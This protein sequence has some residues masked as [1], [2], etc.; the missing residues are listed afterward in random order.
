MATFSRREVLRLAASLGLIPVAGAISACGGSSAASLPSYEFEGQPGPATLFSHAV[1]SGDPLSDAVILWTRVSTQGDEAVSV[2]WEMA[3]DEDFLDRVAAGWE[4]TDSSLDYTVKVDV[5]GLD[6]GA[7]YYYR[8]HALGRMSPVGRTKTA[9]T[10][11]QERMRIGVVS[12]SFYSIGYFHAYRSLAARED[13]DVVVH[14]GDY[15][16][17]YAAG[18][19]R[20]HLPAHEIITLD[21]YRQ[22]YAQYH[23]DP[24]LQAAHRQHPWILVWDDHESAN[25]SWKGGASN[26]Q[27]DEGAWQARKA[28][29]AQA[30]SEWLPIR[31][32][33]DG[34][35]FRSF[36]F[37]DL[38][39]L[40]MLDTRIWGRDKAAG[41]ASDSAVMRDPE[42]TLLGFD[43]EEWVAGEMQSSSARWFVLG[44]QIVM[45]QWKLQGLP[46]AEGGGAVANAD[47]WDGYHAA[48]E[49]LFDAVEDAGRGNLIVLTGD[50]HSS[51]AADLTRDP[52]E[53]SHYDPQTGRGS[54]GVEMV[55]SSVT[56]TFSVP[57]LE[58]VIKTMNP[59]LKYGETVSRGYLLLDLDH[60]RA[61]GEWYHFDDVSKVE[62]T[63][64]LAAIWA[65]RDGAN[66]LEEG[67]AAALPTTPGGT[68]LTDI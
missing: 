1:A 63:E 56:S 44:Q 14:L 22:R 45:H 18:G 66:H 40:T 61:Q 37:G 54:L 27:E 23:T 57:G 43:Q 2:F 16:Y 36:R 65:T 68:G 6:A 17:E 39:D 4:G 28:A 34:R 51:W 33:E 31:D 26:H 64:R 47:Q 13:L 7:T 20:A 10:G 29:A 35:I 12:C 52:N 60:E 41:S 5:Q 15:I 49:R 46:E 58:E 25:N 53:P 50:V 38:L 62:Q 24:D 30:Y 48:R 21:D 11:S 8:F 59:A 42:R 32:Q 3:R 9:P 19:A 67:D 55:C